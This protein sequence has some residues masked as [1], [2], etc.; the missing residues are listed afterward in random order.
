MFSTLLIHKR[1]VIIPQTKTSLVAL[2]CCQKQHGHNECQM[3][4]NIPSIFS[5]SGN[6]FLSVFGCVVCIL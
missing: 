3:D 1:K 6:Y 5:V 2:L 4:C